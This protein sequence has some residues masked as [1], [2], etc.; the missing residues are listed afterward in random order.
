MNDG[1]PIGFEGRLRIGG[2]DRS[3]VVVPTVAWL[4]A[5]RHRRAPEE[6]PVIPEPRPEHPQERPFL[7]EL[8]PEERPREA[9]Y[10]PEPLPEHP[11][12]FPAEPAEF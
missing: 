2:D 11:V 5:A 10:Q 12:E 4:M 1:Q 8:L 3:C 9:P 6:V 7:P